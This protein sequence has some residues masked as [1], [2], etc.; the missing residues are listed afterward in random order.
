MTK[1]HHVDYG[2]VLSDLKAK[3]KELDKA[4]TSIEALS[5]MGLFSSPSNAP[6]IQSIDAQIVE[7][8]GQGT[9]EATAALLKIRPERMKTN[10]IYQTLMNHG[11]IDKNTKLATVAA[12]LYKAVKQKNDCKIKVVGRGEW[13]AN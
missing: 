5:G 10:D 12:T 4:I 6:R 8:R 7:L 13:A 3:R 11:V 9:Y 2:D 1:S